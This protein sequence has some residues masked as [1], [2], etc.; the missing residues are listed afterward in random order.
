MNTPSTGY[1]LK[2]HLM[3]YE[4]RKKKNV[5]QHEKSIIIN[6]ARWKQK[7]PQCSEFCLE[8]FTNWLCCKLSAVRFDLLISFSCCCC[9]LFISLHLKYYEIAHDWTT[10]EK[11]RQTKMP[12]KAKADNNN[13]DQAIGCYFVEMEL[14][15]PKRKQKNVISMG[16]QKSKRYV[17]QMNANCKYKKKKCVTLSSWEWQIPQ[18][19][20]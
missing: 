17:H 4:R 1:C 6:K 2:I 15:E 18:L 12:A 7:K 3:G 5:Q 13:K 8:S 11:R 9:F 10:G 19:N 20:S 16:W 14:F